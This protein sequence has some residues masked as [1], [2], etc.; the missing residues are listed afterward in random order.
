MNRK[1]DNAGFESCMHDLF[2][3]YSGSGYNLGRGKGTVNNCS[4]R[5]LKKQRNVPY[6]QSDP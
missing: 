2:I 4:T 6:E 1:R 3:G 5:P